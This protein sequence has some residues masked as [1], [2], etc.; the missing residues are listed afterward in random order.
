MSDE[1]GELGVTQRAVSPCALAPGVPQIY[2]P[3]AA[4][5][6]MDVNYRCSLI[7]LAAPVRARIFCV[8]QAFV[9][10]SLNNVLA[11]PPLLRS[12]TH[13]ASAKIALLFASG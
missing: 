10:L 7:A 1:R 4:A 9:C 11:L 3:K 2:F 12:Q 8:V 13:K 5:Q 6:A